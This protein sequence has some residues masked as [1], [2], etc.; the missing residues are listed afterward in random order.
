MIQIPF[1]LPTA[2]AILALIGIA[3]GPCDPCDDSSSGNGD[4]MV[5]LDTGRFAV[6]DDIPT[7]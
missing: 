3:A 1:A 2:F 6:G 4:A 7:G 5:S